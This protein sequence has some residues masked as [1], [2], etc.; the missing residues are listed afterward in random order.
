MLKKVLTALLAFS[1]CFGCLASCSDETA[2]E[3]SGIEST[4]KEESSTQNEASKNDESSKDVNIST[5]ATSVAEIEK[6]AGFKFFR[7]LNPAIAEAVKSQK[8]LS[9]W[10]L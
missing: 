4:E 5:A 9:D 1:M 8:R 10:G 2:S 6:R 7:N 3:S